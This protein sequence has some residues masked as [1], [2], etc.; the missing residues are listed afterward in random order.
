MFSA[1]LFDFDG[2]IVNTDPIHYKIWKDF[3]LEYNVEINEEIFK[4]NFA[5]RHNPDIIQDVLPHLSAEESERFAQ[6]KEARFREQAS[7]LKTI[8]GF[9][10]L[11][12]WSKQHHL[13]CALVTN[14]PKLNAY[15][16][17][18]ALQ[19]K[20]AFDII[21]LGEEQTAAKPDPTPYKVALEK[22]GLQPQ[23]AIAIE[24]SP[25]GMRSAVDA[26]IRTIGITST[27]APETLQNLGAFM[28][29]SD[30]AD[31]QLWT[32]LN[33]LLSID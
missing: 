18:E 26:G 8:S 19:L 15:H 9:T 25:S 21:I 7:L 6:E 3:L 16:M 14:A 29:I 23:E 22:L 24:D 5:G 11:F 27:Q 33:S 13:K 10:Q 12:A 28:T 32:F 20:E 4:S 31:S 30:F 2:T 17:L 1:I